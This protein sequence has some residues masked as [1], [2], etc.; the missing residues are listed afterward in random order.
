[1]VDSH[2][3][4]FAAEF[5]VPTP[6]QVFFVIQ[7]LWTGV[8][9]VLCTYDPEWSPITDNGVFTREGSKEKFVH[10]NVRGGWNVRGG[11]MFLV[12]AGALYFGTRETYIVAMASAIWR[13]AYDCI[14]LTLCKPGGEKIVLRVWSSPFGPQPPL[15]VFLLLNVLAMWAILTAA[16]R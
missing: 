15:I 2:N 1:M 10:P 12:T 9:G 4:L 16:V 6:V 11:S 14:E 5:L 8:M 7:C 3:G 13:E